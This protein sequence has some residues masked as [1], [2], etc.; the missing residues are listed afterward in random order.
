MILRSLV[1]LDHCLFRTA[2]HHHHWDARL[3]VQGCSVEHDSI[4]ID[5]ILLASP[6]ELLVRST[7]PRNVQ[8]G[9]QNKEYCNTA[10]TSTSCPE[11][12]QRVFTS[13]AVSHRRSGHISHSSISCLTSHVLLGFALPRRQVQVSACSFCYDIGATLQQS[14]K[15]P[16]DASRFTSCGC[17]GVLIALTRAPKPLVPFRLG[18]KATNITTRAT[19][20]IPSTQPLRRLT[21]LAPPPHRTRP[22]T[23][24][25]QSR[26]AIYHSHVDSRS[27]IV[28]NHAWRKRWDSDTS[29]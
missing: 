4:S 14:H 7:R 8:L 16:A 12:P 3:R 23:S 24:R 13:H 6:P 2:L 10:P 27:K 22:Q 19:T 9:N 26:I 29:F 18:A 25:S 21:D 28:L 5:F 1:K 17:L 11:L 15:R 20:S